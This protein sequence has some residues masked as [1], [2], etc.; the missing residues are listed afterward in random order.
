MTAGIVEIISGFAVFAGLCVIVGAAAMLSPVLALFV[1]GAFVVLA[2]A[3]GLYVA[4]SLDR[5]TPKKVTS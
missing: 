1:A 4:A 5:E 2:G 3:L